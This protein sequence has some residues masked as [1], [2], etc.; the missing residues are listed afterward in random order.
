MKLP[1]RFVAASV[2]TLV[3]LPATAQMPAGY[4]ATYTDTI[5]AAKKEGKVVI[6]STTDTAAAGSLIKDFQVLYPGISVE[7]NDMNSTELYNRYISERAAGGGSADVLWSSAMDLQIKLVSDGNAMAYT[8]PEVPSMPAWSVWRNEAYGTTYEPIA[9]VYNKRLLSGDE[10][11][12]SHA[13]LMRVFAQK[14]D[15]LKGK[16]TTYDIEK[17]GVGFLLIT[18]DS[19]YNPAFWDL[20]RALGV[21]GPRFQ[22]S[23]G[24]MMERISS[25]ENLL[26]FNIFASY[27]ALRAKKDPSIGIVYPKDYTLVMSRVMFASKGAKNPN[28]AKLWLDYMLSRR[29]Q[30]LIANQAELG[31]IRADVDGEMTAAGLAKTLGATVKPIP[32]SAELLGYLDQSKRLEF[33]KQWQQAIKAGK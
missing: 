1:A 9:I 27:A 12:Q 3:L 10:I 16:V 6:Y 29:G 11:P 32:V 2:L 5:A 14:A 8:S 31:S 17:S 21:A 25:G 19:K 26:G 30:T 23:A 18:Q 24:T 28:A 22:S 20:V 13:D 7:Y 15:K 4:P 33:L